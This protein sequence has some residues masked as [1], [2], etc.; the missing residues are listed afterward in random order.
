MA[1]E[2]RAASARRGYMVGRRAVA[3]ADDGRT[4]VTRERQWGA[5]IGHD[6]ALGIDDIDA[7][8]HHVVATGT[9]LVVVGGEA[10]RHRL[11]GGL[12][13]GGGDHGAT[14]ASAGLEAARGVRDSGSD[15]PG[16]GHLHRRDRL[17]VHE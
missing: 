8:D 7:C 16:G 5:G 10:Q 11:A 2:S 3:R 15:R 1:V 6:A 14:L 4:P 9:A 12:A 13:R 17:A